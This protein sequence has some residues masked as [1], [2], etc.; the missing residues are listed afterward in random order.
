MFHY[1]DF[2]YS[3]RTY[4]HIDMAKTGEVVA[5]VIDKY[6]KI[7]EFNFYKSDIEFLIPL[8]MQCTLMQPAK[9]IYENIKNIELDDSF[10]LLRWV[11]L[12]R[13]FIFVAQRFLC[14]H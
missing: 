5:E 1:A 3:Y 4:P 7:K 14:I 13:M 10:F 9:K 11:F 12:L 2:I 6:Q 8:H